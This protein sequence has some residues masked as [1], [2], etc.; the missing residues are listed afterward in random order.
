MRRGI[1]L[2]FFGYGNLLRSID[3]RLAAEGLGRAHHRALHFIARRPD[4]TVGALLGLL[5]VTKQ[6]LGRTLGELVTRGLVE[7]RVG[8]DDRRQRL[9]RLTPVGAALEA[10]LFD[11]L[12]ETLAAAY[13]AAGPAAVGGFWQVLEGLLPASRRDRTP[14]PE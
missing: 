7:M 3:A 6:S 1:E 10:D 4:L 8:R 9:L 5:G 12:R 13:S 11:A 2:L 14:S